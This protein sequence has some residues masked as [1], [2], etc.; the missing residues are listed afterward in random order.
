MSPVGKT[1]DAGWEIGVSRTV[2][3][4]IEVVWRALTSGRGL[5]TWLGRGVQLPAEPGTPYRTTDGT[6]G[7]IR[8]F[9]PGDRVRLTWRGATWTHDTTVQVALSPSAT[10]GTTI[11]F[12]QER[13]ADSGER[14][15]QR[16]HWQNVLDR[17]T[18]LL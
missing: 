6:T 16:A 18:P 14:E 17:L 2:D 15:R 8:S 10:G 3:R 1:Q 11:R 5:S 9:R 7:E 13:L 4:P 12:H